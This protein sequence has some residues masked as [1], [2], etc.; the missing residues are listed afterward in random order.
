MGNT[1]ACCG[2]DSNKFDKS[3]QPLQSQEVLG[4]ADKAPTPGFHTKAEIGMIGK[5]D[6]QNG[7]NNSKMDGDED[8]TINFEDGSTYQG[9]VINGKRHGKGIWQSR[10]GQY[11]GQWKDDMQH[12]SGAQTWSDGRSYKGEFCQGKFSG[13]GKMEWHTAKGH[14]TYEGQYVND[15]K[16]GQGKFSWSDGRHYT[17]EWLKGKRHGKGVYTNAKGETKKGIW[18]QDKFEKWL[19]ENE[20]A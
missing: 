6:V 12:G 2:N 7:D 5:G 20:A 11:D 8:E 13:K 15:L 14:L 10:T 19:D 4:V 9:Q 17:G 16:E 1:C 18:A 3:G